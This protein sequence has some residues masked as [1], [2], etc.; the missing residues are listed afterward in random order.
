MDKYFSTDLRI[1]WIPNNRI[2]FS[3][4]GN[5]LFDPK[6]SEYYWYEV[7]RIFYGKVEIRF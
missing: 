5:N 2:E 4:A 7:E 1:A 6:H 3:I